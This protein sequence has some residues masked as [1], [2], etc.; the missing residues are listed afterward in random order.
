QAP[1][2]QQPRERGKRQQPE[3]VSPPGAI[4]GREHRH[5]VS[6]LRGGLAVEV[7]SP[8]AENIIALRQIRIVFARFLRPR[9][10]TLIE[11]VE[12][13][14]VFGAGLILKRRRSKLEAE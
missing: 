3:P 7:A 8:D 4:P 6:S 14:A 1:V 12:I 2:N 13:D 5:T 9:G 11:A 10:P